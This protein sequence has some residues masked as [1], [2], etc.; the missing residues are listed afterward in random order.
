[1]SCGRPLAGLALAVLPLT[2]SAK[3]ASEVFALA[4]PSVVVVRT[5]DE[6]FTPRTQ[7]SGVVLPGQTVATN[8]HVLAQAAWIV[9][10]DGGAPRPATVAYADDERDVC[11]LRVPGLTAPPARLGSTAALP[12]GAPV[13]AIG[14]P[15]GLELTLSEGIVSSFRGQ[16]GDRLIQTTAPIS[17]G[18]SGGGLFDAE[19]QLVGL[20]TFLLKNSQQLNFAVPVEWVKAGLPREAIPPQPVT[21]P[22]V[23]PDIAK[24]PPLR[25][26]KKWAEVERDPR[27]Q[28]LSSEDKE[29]ARQQY[30]DDVVKPQVIESGMDLKEARMQFDAATRPGKSS[31]P[32]PAQPA[33]RSP[34]GIARMLV[35]S[36][37]WPA[38]LQHTQ[39]WTAAAP[40]NADAWYALGVAYYHTGQKGLTTDVYSRLKGLDAATAEAFFK[41]YVLP[42]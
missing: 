27:Y 42:R 26:P 6:R 24:P 31:I 25:L 13:Y 7:G 18:S 1:M 32:A 38:L 37:D 36:E 35:E 21:P 2:L 19:G 40:D 17:P 4:S 22:A 3:S 10:S 39:T 34:R 11:L 33:D 23:R 29:A 14:T 9:V 20:P 8:C 16:G 41:G 15:R 30:F 12:I 5:V 28:A